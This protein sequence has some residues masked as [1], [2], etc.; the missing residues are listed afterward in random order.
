MDPSTSD[1]DTQVEA[2]RSADVMVVPGGAALAN[3][4]FV[5]PTTT[6]IGLVA[7]SRPPKTFWR[8]L[9]EA[10][11]SPYVE[12]PVMVLPS[13]TSLLPRHHRDVIVTPASVVRLTRE[14]RRVRTPVTRWPRWLRS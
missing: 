4:L 12:V 1:L 7:R 2:Y 14:I 6:T 3:M 5:S 13:L 10:L 11:D 8:D 9:A